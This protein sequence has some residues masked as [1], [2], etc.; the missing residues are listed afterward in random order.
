MTSWTEDYQRHRPCGFGIH[1]V[2]R[3]K[4]FYSQ[5][6][7][8]HGEDS[9]EKFLDVIQREAKLI[10]QYLSTKIEM[11]TLSRRQTRHYYSA[12][13]CHICGN[14]FTRTTD[15]NFW[16]VRDHDHLTGKFR[17]AAHSI[18]NL[19]YNVD[20]DRVKIPCVIHNLKNYDAH[21]LLSALKLRFGK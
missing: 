8:Y 14:L 1:T 21:L 19:Q 3:D 2:C 13:N 11:E 15:K 9:A 17:G 10:R 20:P 4:R 5:P 7:V 18:C 16:R 6:K 12:R